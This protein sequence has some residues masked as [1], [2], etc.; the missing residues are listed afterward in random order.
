MTKFWRCNLKVKV[1]NIS[2]SKRHSF[3]LMKNNVFFTSIACVTA[4]Q[5]IGHWSC[6]WHEVLIVFQLRYRFW[7]RL[8]ILFYFILIK[9]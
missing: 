8:F 1:K 2:Q 3:F 4:L 9:T 7:R 5:L 6:Y